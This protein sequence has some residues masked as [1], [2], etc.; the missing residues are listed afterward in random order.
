[1]GTKHTQGVN[2]NQSTKSHMVYYPR[3]RILRLLL[4]I[5]Y[6]VEYRY[7]YMK[8]IWINFYEKIITQ[9]KK[10][11]KFQNYFLPCYN[12]IYPTKGLFSVATIHSLPWCLF[13]SISVIGDKAITR[14]CGHLIFLFEILT[15]TKIFILKVSDFAKEKRKYFWYN[16]HYVFI[17]NK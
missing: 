16:T 14:I 15:Q 17:I 13:M 12:V 8:L 9:Y 3:K 7:V 1:M 11:E 10:F 2:K 5:S 6:I 4:I